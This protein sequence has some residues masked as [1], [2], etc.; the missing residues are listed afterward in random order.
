MDKNQ[1]IEA[2]ATAHADALYAG[3][4]LHSQKRQEV[5]DGLQKY[6]PSNLKEVFDDFVVL[7]VQSNH[8]IEDHEEY[9]L[10]AMNPEWGG[11]L[12]EHPRYE[13]FLEEMEINYATEVILPV[14]EKTLGLTLD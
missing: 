6:S 10:Y 14:V 3:T 7:F 8:D 11:D 2:F 9:G 12:S 4:D 1:I 5:I 13:E